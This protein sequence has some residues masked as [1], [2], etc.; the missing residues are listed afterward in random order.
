M[1]ADKTPDEPETEEKSEAVEETKDEE[2]DEEATEAT[3]VTENDA[4]EASDMVE[5]AAPV[6][7]PEVEEHN[8]AAEEPTEEEHNPKDDAEV[9]EADTELEAEPET[10][11]KEK[12]EEEE[13]EEEPEVVKSETPES[14]KV[15]VI[16]GVV[17]GEDEVETLNNDENNE[18]LNGATGGVLMDSD[19]TELVETGNM[20]QLATLV[21][22]GEGDR[23]I[24]QQ[25][26]NPEIQ[27]FLENVPIYMVC[28]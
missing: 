17:N 23:L 19:I 21:L 12:E 6:P 3:E 28:K 2:K 9:I 22:N 25:S 14:Q 20:E 15:G 26:N 10:A 7:E 4:T 13:E 5:E 8:G 1:S 16:E 11:E 27:A 18:D 24:G